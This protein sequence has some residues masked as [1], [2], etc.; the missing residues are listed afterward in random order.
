MAPSDNSALIRFYAALDDLDRGIGGMRRFAECSGR[1]RWPSRGLYFFF[2][3]GEYL[4]E[5]KNR[6]RVVRVGTH[7]VSINS[8]ST[9]W[10]RLK[11]HKGNANGG[12]NH[13]SSIFRQHTGFALIKSGRVG[14]ECPTWGIGMVR[15]SPSLL[16]EDRIEREVS[17]YLGTMSVLW[18]AVGDQPGP[19]SDRAF[20]E[21][22]IIALLARHNTQQTSENW[23]G[24]YS[25]NESIRVSRLWNVD[26]V[27]RHFDDRAVTVFEN[28][29][30]L[31]VNGKSPPE[32][33]LAPQGWARWEVGAELPLEASI[34]PLPSPLA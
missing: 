25:P 34:S 14:S 15:P 10:H 19:Q 8:R 13:R 33:S 27:R 6:L 30:D 32:R 31:A 5:H 12:G 24:N 7:A 29:V 20:L 2:E 1:D 26:H 23:L 17:A 22:N 21:R 9:L 16:C 11:T 4:G 3:P 18:I 28:Y